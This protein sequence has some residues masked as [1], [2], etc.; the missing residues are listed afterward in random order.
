MS[1]P[2]LQKSAESIEGAINGFIV[3]QFCVKKK[4]PP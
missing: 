2:K 4:K 1:L 3:N